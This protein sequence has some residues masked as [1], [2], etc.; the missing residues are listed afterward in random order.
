MPP[1]SHSFSRAPRASVIVPAYNAAAT[2]AE[3]LESLLAQTFTDFEIVIV[4]DGTPDRTLDVVALYDDPRIRVVRQ[5]NRGLAGARNGGLMAARG[6]YVGFCD[7]DDLWEPG[8][9]AA[10]VAHLDADPE[11][12][13]SFSGSRLIDA[14]SRPLGLAQSPK[15]KGITALDV[16]CR[17]PIGNGSAA[18]VRRAAFDRI[19][20][21]PATDSRPWWFDERFRQSEDIECWARFV[22]STDWKIE[23]VPGLLTR[24]RVNP[25]GLSANLEKQYESWERMIDRMAEISPSFVAR[26]APAARAYQ[27]R[28]L[29][30]RAVSQ[31]DGRL[32]MSLLARAL[33]ASHRPLLVE[34]AKTCSTIAAAAL[35]SAFG[36]DGYALAERAIL[37][38]RS[39]F[40]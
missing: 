20:W 23:G 19:A 15:L 26:H 13:I 25:G 18:V 4:D 35:L 6:A 32:A 7:A 12:G 36:R 5:A 31:R 3:T 24:Y 14:A 10:H 34:P 30:R 9:L 33:N 28:Y 40:A 39:R 37:T 22:L 17:N 16:L 21:R 1:A 8:K 38:A 29:A 2:I 11:V 27:L